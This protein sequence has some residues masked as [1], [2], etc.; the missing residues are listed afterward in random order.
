MHPLVEYWVSVKGAR[1]HPGQKVDAEMNRTRRRRSRFRG[2][3]RVLGA[4]SS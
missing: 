4:T 3:A 1:D 2:D